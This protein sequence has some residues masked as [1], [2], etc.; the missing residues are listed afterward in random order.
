MATDND[1]FTTVPKKKTHVKKTLYIGNLPT[2]RSESDLR[3][4]LVTVFK[5]EMQV[6]V[7]A[8]AFDFHKSK[9]CHAF[10][11][12]DGDL[13]AIIRKLNSKIFWGKRLVVQRQ[14]K[15]RKTSVN[16]QF[17]SSWSKPKQ[18]QTLP[19]PREGVFKEVIEQEM[20]KTKDPIA[21]ALAAAPAVGIVSSVPSNDGFQASQPLSEL[22]ADYGEQDLNW[23]NAQPTD[24]PM[25]RE[26]NKN[27]IGSSTSR[28]Q[29]CGKAPI[30][31]DLVSFG[32]HHGAPAELRNGW[33]HAQPLP[34]FDCRDLSEVP[35]YLA[36]QDGLSGAVKRALM[37]PR[38]SNNNEPIGKSIRLVSEEAG[39]KILK[40]L[41][42][43]VDDGGYGYTSPLR[44]TVYVGSESGR[45]RSV[46]L[47]ELV[48]TALRKR[49][50]ANKADI[51]QQPCSV[52]TRHRDLERKVKK[53]AP[54]AAKLAGMDDD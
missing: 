48:A 21:A 17:T 3:E 40:A 11:E 39:D 41:V 18:V 44:M 35:H 54:S 8:A 12:Y 36:W 14:R 9:S 4:E 26:K 27:S 53:P 42:D 19:G 10:L 5:N 1:E 2:D 51:V 22:L 49:L 20:S 13:A 32:F 28:L 38:D 50:R 31:V 30:H 6:D 24:D 29:Q 7:S 34:V 46:V 37:Y 47:C 52:S 25:S 15:Q 43:A 16:G 23:K 45:H 33:S